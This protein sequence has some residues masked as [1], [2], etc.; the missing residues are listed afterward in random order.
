MNNARL[1]LA[2]VALFASATFTG[3]GAE[4]STAAEMDHAG[5]GSTGSGESAVPSATASASPEDAQPEGKTI[6]IDVT[7]GKPTPP[8]HLVPVSLGESVTLVVTSDVADE[9]HLH[10]YDAHVDLVAGQEGK[11]TFKADIPGR[12]EAELE[13]TGTLLIEL[14][15]R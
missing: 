13:G 6:R 12:F 11:L 15:V 2:A 5:H 9:V 1:V 7:G 10:G 3:C 8:A 14:E 4:E